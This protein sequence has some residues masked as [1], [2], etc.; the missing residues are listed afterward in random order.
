M[1]VRLLRFDRSRSVMVN[2]KRFNPDLQ[3]YSLRWQA[4]EMPAQPK[5]IPW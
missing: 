1:A 5:R 4:V 2:S 3:Q